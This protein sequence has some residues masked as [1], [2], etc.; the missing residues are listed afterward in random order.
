[1]RRGSADAQG[2]SSCRA[3]A[4]GAG[5]AYTGVRDGMS[6]MWPMTRPRRHGPGLNHPAET[7]LRAEAGAEGGTTGCYDRRRG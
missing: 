5:R 1:M 3:M 4:G 7:G 6:G 2:P